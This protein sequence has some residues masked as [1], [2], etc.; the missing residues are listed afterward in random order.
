MSD[1]SNSGCG[2]KCWQGAA[3]AGGVLF[4]LLKFAAGFGLLASLFLGVVI[5]AGLGTLL[6][7]MVCTETAE[8]GAI[9]STAAAARAS[10]AAAP[11]AAA[12][13]PTPQ[14]DPMDVPATAPEADPQTT[15]E[16]AVVQ[17]STALP[18]EADLA[19][20]KG[21]WAYTPVAEAQPA[22]LLKPS[23]PLAGEADLAARKGSWTYRPQSA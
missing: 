12:V 2:K 15:P 17:P 21:D 8:T 20:R 1:T 6:V 22:P 13:A 19:A 10:A 4:L 3:I 7:R 18:G 9:S 11:A 16:R 5:T 14:P 23:T